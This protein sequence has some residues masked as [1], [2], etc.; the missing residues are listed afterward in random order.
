MT[1]PAVA[2]CWYVKD[3]AL[4]KWGRG[5]QCD[6]WQSSVLQRGR[7]QGC[8]EEFTLSHLLILVDH[9][10]SSP[11]YSAVSRS[12]ATPDNTKAGSSSRS[13]SINSSALRH[14][15]HHHLLTCL[16]EQINGSVYIPGLWA[17]CGWKIKGQRGVGGGG[18]KAAE[19]GGRAK[20]PPPALRMDQWSN[21]RTNRWSNP[22]VILLLSVSLGISKHS[23]HPTEGIC[24]S[25]LW[26]RYIER[27]VAMDTS[28]RKFT[29][30]RWFSIYLKNK[31][32]RNKSNAGFC[33]L[34]VSQ[35]KL[36]SINSLEIRNEKGTNIIQWHLVYEKN[37]ILSENDAVWSMLPH[38]YKQKKVWLM[39]IC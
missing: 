23:Q 25:S 14:H 15:H 5:V 21:C 34:E 4:K 39:N 20:E 17:C 31:A 8:E 3:G 38:K 32:A 9:I 1:S 2:V 33:Q 37:C 19:N 6:W 16:G 24:S 18:G 26:D 11:L 27:V 28:T 13:S 12:N 36:T 29:V 22:P 7:Q 10:Y 30:R 35:I